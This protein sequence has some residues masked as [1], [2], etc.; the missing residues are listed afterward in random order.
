M[1]G[2]PS[3]SWP[4]H[5]TTKNLHLVIL[6]CPLILLYTQLIVQYLTDYIF[7]TIKLFFM[8][9][10]ASIVDFGKTILKNLNHIRLSSTPELILYVIYTLLWPG[11]YYRFYIIKAKVFDLYQVKASVLLVLVHQLGL[12]ILPDIM[13]LPVSQWSLVLLLPLYWPTHHI[14]VD[15]FPTFST[16][17]AV[18]RVLS[19]WVPLSQY[20]KFS[21]CFCF[22]WA[23]VLCFVCYI[24]WS[25]IL[26]PLM[27]FSTCF[28][29]LCVS[30]LWSQ[31]HNLLLV[32]SSMSF[33]VDSFLQISLLMP[34]HLAYVWIV[35][36]AFYHI[37]DSHILL[38]L[39]ATCPFIL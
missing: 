20:M 14:E 4:S 35:L 38:P 21:T 13:N 19:L 31:N 5:G 6:L 7:N 22:L 11:K 3:S 15:I 1:S 34:H 16:S 10:N 29:T 18:C 36:L 12:I 28:C 27:L 32:E 24:G 8:A 26:W 2:I 23:S 9:I 30:T 37:H 25:Q 17:L 33:N 39:S